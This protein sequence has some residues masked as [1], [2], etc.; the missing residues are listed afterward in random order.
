[1]R[2]SIPAFASSQSRSACSRVEQNTA[3]P[4]PDSAT[5]PR[6][7]H[8][9]GGDSRMCV[10][11]GPYLIVSTWNGGPALIRFKRQPSIPSAM[12]AIVPRFA[13]NNSFKADAYGAA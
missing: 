9:C 4:V 13:S 11:C 8:T 6:A 10:Y 12:S 3:P 7:S 1:M 2:S 5:T